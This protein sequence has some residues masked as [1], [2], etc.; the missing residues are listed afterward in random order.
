MIGKPTTIG[1]TVVALPDLICDYEG[2][3]VEKIISIHKHTDTKT[4]GFSSG[5]GYA[6]I[7]STWRKK[8]AFS[9]CCWHKSRE[10]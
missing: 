10:T 5:Q 7:C 8:C 6:N 2:Q 9:A 1:R 3:E 4:S